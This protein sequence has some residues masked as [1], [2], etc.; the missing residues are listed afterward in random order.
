MGKNLNY[1]STLLPQSNTT[2]EINKGILDLLKKINE[3]NSEIDK[4]NSKIVSLEN[5]SK[6]GSYTPVATALN[7]VAAV[8]VNKATYMY[9]DG[10]V[11][12]YGS[13]LLRSITT[14]LWTLELDIP[15]PSDI[16]IATDLVGTISTIMAS[17]SQ[18]VIGGV[19]NNTALLSAITPTSVASFIYVYNYQYEVIK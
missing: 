4:S 1:Q 13:V 11:N 14:S 6:G 3:T 10:I 15:I 7:N 5:S 12:V 16:I 9:V 2:D 17:N 8:T 18:Y 19:S